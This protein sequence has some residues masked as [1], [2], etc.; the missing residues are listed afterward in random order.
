MQISIYTGSRAVNSKSM[1]RTL[2]NPIKPQVDD[3]QEDDF[4]L[5]GMKENMYGIREIFP[6]R[7]STFMPVVSCYIQ[8]WINKA[9]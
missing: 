3:L 7:S 8:S 4:L 5:L 6:I 9:A 2:Y 1:D